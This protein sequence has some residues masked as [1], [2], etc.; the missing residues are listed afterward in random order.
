[1]HLDSGHKELMIGSTVSIRVRSNVRHRASPSGSYLYVV[2][3]V[4][5]SVARG[6]PGRRMCVFTAKLQ[7]HRLLF[8]QLW[9]RSPSM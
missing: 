4:P 3:L 7:G 9:N 1:M 5:T 8:P 6:H 2:Y